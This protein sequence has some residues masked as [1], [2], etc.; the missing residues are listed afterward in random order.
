LGIADKQKLFRAL[1]WTR[2]RTSLF[3]RNLRFKDQKKAIEILTDL[4][5]QL[6]ANL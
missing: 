6:K 3:P 2:S 5:E 1:N 4:L